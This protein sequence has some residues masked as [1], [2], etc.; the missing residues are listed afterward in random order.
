VG[1]A[2]ALEALRAAAEGAH[3]TGPFAARAK[4]EALAEL[5]GLQARLARARLSGAV[6][7]GAVAREAAA[8]AREAAAAGDL[9]A[10]GVATRGLARLG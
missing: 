3:A 6:P 4:A 7:E 9:V 8:L 2:F 5:G 1:E 10:I